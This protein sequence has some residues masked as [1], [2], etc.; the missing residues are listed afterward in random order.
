[1]IAASAAAGSPG[2][3]PRPAWRGRLHLWAAPVAAAVALTYIIAA[4]GLRER[5]GVGVWGLTLTGLFGVSAAYHRG[6]WGPVA[7]AW[8]QRV[9]HAMI[10]VFIA[11]SYTPI[12][13]MLLAGRSSWLT[14]TIAWG[15]ALAGVVIRLTWHTAPRWLFVPMYLALGWVA[16]A[17]MPDLAAGAPRYALWLLVAGGVLYS[18]GAFVFALRWP[19]P[20]PNV[21]GFHE[22]FHAMTIA[23]AGCHAVAIAG[24]VASSGIA[25]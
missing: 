15:G 14:L 24:A 6:R 9:D 17:V 16:V 1:M 20:A 23:A 25:S 22:V 10:F 4:E 3:V 7:K 12:C 8:W 19:D 5:L 13:L 18:L 21:F 11:G 2:L